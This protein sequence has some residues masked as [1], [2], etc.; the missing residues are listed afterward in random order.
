MRSLRSTAHNDGILIE[1][2][3]WDDGELECLE[4]FLHS[5]GA[6][7][8]R[9]VDQGEEEVPGRGDETWLLERAAKQGE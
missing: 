9:D 4:R 3:E 7:F 6:S 8:T 2:V 1:L 5:L